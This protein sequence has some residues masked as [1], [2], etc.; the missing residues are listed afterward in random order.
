M[1]NPVLY[2]MDR[3]RFLG[4]STGGILIGIAG[5]VSDRDDDAMRLTNILPDSEGPGPL[6]IEIEVLGGYPIRGIVPRAG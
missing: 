5:C 2:A 3:R 4:V 1:I 6:T